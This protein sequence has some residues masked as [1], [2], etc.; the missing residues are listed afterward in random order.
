MTEA[1]IAEKHDLEV[2][3][4]Q[5]VL[6]AFVEELADAKNERKEEREVAMRE[7]NVR[8]Q[9]GRWTAA[10]RRREQAVGGF[11]RAQGVWGDG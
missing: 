3:E 2:E 10:V 6:E 9:M 5:D 4:E 1:R 8:V 11:R 7:R